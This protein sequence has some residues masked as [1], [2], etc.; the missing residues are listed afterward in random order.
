[1]SSCR[2]EDEL[3]PR[4]SSRSFPHMSIYGLAIRH[5]SLVHRGSSSSI[6]PEQDIVST[7]GAGS[8]L[9]S[10]VTPRPMKYFRVFTHNIVFMANLNKHCS[11]GGNRIREETINPWITWISCSS[12]VSVCSV[13]INPLRRMVIH[14]VYLL[15][16]QNL[17]IS[18]VIM[19]RTK[20][21]I[22][23]NI[24]V[25]FLFVLFVLRI[26]N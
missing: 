25:F 4:S 10:F 5:G 1:M 6:R 17:D 9:F 11:G 7:E 24:K 12:G 21:R 8:L 15:L 19:K 13:V 23:G 26:V 14:C 16:W 20:R 22:K 18:S 3:L 2:E